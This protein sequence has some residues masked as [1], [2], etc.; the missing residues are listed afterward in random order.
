MFGPLTLKSR[1]VELP[2]RNR[3]E[4]IQLDLVAPDWS[5]R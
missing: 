5:F 4:S 3:P 2:D 1:T